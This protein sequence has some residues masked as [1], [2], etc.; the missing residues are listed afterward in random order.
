MSY[1]GFWKQHFECDLCVSRFSN[2]NRSW[3]CSSGETLNSTLH[4]LLLAQNNVLCDLCV[5]HLNFLIRLVILHTSS[6]TFCI[7]S[8]W[9]LPAQWCQV[10]LCLS[11]KDAMFR[12]RPPAWRFGHQPCGHQAAPVASTAIASIH[13][14][15]LQK[16]GILGMHH[17]SIISE[18]TPYVWKAMLSQGII[19]GAQTQ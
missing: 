11:T 18:E 8:L 10:V 3:T 1:F 14:C 12:R 15:R 16:R 19:P 9:L 2:R 6:Y 4:K 13:V 7:S 17:T 5:I